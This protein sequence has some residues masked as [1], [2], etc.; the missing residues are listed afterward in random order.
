MTF[1]SKAWSY[2]LAPMAKAARWPKPVCARCTCPACGHRAGDQ[3]GGTTAGARNADEVGRSDC[4]EHQRGRASLP[5]KVIG[6]GTHQGDAMAWR[7]RRS[8]G[9][10]VFVSDE[11]CS[12]VGGGSE[13]S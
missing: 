9:P 3:R 2:E 10:V 8:F 4:G 7:R 5:S 6:G 13:V 11:Q 1:W 12:V